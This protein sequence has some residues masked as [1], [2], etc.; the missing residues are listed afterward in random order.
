MDFYKKL[1]VPMSQPNISDLEIELVNAVLKSDSLSMGPYLREFE[2]RIASVA[3]SKHAVAVNSG[4]AGL[5]C[6]VRAAG[7]GA[8]HYVITSPFSFVASVNA[9]LYE[10]VT[11]ILV[12]VDPLTGNIDPA[13]VFQAAEDLTC[14]GEA[15]RKWLP[16]KNSGPMG[17]LK[18]ILAVDVFGQPADY[19]ALNE[20]ARKANLEVIEDSCEAIGAA[21]K[22]RPAGSLADFGVFAFY[23]NKQMTTGEGG[24]VVTND[25]DSAMMIRA[26][27]NQGRAPSDTWLDHTYLGFNYRMDEMSAALGVAQL[28][29][30]P[31]LLEARSQVADW[32]E[33]ELKDIPGIELP[34]KAATT[35]YTSW[36]VYVIRLDRSINRNEVI[37]K[38]DALGIPSRP[39]FSPIHLQ[40]Y[41]VEK[42]GYRAGDF[43]IAEDLG[44][45]GLA[46]PFSSKLNRN[47]VYQVAS[48]LRQV[49]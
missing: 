39:Y 11:P 3:N 18:G 36:F 34:Q 30:L 2:E 41:M 48:A 1:N 7:W 15:S 31:S 26:L 42:F 44:A 13:L 4:T 43:P 21:Y 32:Y 45:R 6:C 25:A 46:I 17:T 33:E 19:D 14:Q 20:T 22:G 8:G 24:V 12:D 10:G 27:R 23:P 38:L 40:P 29:R 5:H 37:R 49:L 16:E 47:Q 9:L 35:T 28:R